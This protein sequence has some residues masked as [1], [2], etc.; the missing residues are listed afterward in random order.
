MQEHGME[1][2]IRSNLQ[3]DGVET[4]ASGKLF[5]ATLRQAL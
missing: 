5:K 2:P 4:R 3:I 1:K